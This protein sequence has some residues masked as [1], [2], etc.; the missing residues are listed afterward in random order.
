MVWRA[1]VAPYRERLRGGRNRASEEM[2]LR[3]P[4]HYFD[5]ETG[6]HYN[7]FRYYSPNFR[8]YLQP[9]P[10]GTAA[11]NNLY[12]YTANP[13]KEVDFRGD[14]STDGT[15]K[16]KRKTTE[17]GESAEGPLPRNKGPVTRRQ[18]QRR[19]RRNVST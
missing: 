11:G 1:R 3:F 5:P 16:N 9:D 19:R 17:D 7:R 10:L 8:S 14:C 4:G 2:P 12:A 18:E 13:L 15:D 6:L